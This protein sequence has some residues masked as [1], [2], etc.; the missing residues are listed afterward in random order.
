ME[1]EI[2]TTYKEYKNGATQVAGFGRLGCYQGLDYL[3]SLL[4]TDR[5]YSERLEDD[6]VFIVNYIN[7]I[8]TQLKKQK[9]IIDKLRELNLTISDSDYVYSQDEI[10]NKNLELLQMLEDKEV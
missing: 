4:D 2:A 3:D 9:E 7:S 6:I 5:Y 8:E 10:T 1:K